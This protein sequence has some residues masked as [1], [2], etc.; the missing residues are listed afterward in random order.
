MTLRYAVRNDGPE[1]ASAGRRVTR[2]AGK[3]TGP[4]AEH[5]L[6]ARRAAKRAKA[7]ERVTEVTAARRAHRSRNA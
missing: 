4:L 7:M 3:Q 2:T 5:R 1:R 6:S